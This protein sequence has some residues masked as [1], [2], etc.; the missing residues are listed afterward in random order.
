MDFHS[1][2]IYA[3]HHVLDRA[4]LSRG[5]HGLKNQQQPPIALRIQLVL[6]LAQQHDSLFRYSLRF[7]LI[8][9]FQIARVPRVMILQPKILRRLHHIRLDELMN[10]LCLHPFH[11]YPRN[12]RRL[13]SA[14][15][16]LFLCELCVKS[17]S[18]LLP[19]LFLKQT[20]PNSQSF[21][22]LTS[23]ILPPTIAYSTPP[24]FTRFEA[25]PA[26]QTAK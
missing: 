15:S 2:W 3:G 6:H 17:F 11:R 21:A 23:L 14:S 16:V 10:T 7:G 8:P 19:N 22:A 13:F 9:R 4:V 1:L 12:P 18:F 20:Q 25:N 24:H 26:T 5:I